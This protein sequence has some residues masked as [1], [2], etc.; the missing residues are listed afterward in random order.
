MALE[1]HFWADARRPDF[2]NT[3]C[4]VREAIVFALK[5]AG[6]QLPDPDARVL[7]PGD[8]QPWRAVF[9]KELNGSIP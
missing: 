4:H 5:A 3:S 8:P 6:V 7:S 2:V 1:A 9:A